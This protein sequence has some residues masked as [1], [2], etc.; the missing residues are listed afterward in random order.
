MV[1]D[2]FL[3][4]NNYEHD[5]GANFG[6]VSGK[7]IRHVIGTVLPEIGQRNGITG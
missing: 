3:H 7:Y 2:L 4:V 5:D 1:Y 6:I